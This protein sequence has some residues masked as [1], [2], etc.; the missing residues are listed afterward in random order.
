VLALLILGFPIILVVAWV[1]ELT[2]KGLVRDTDDGAESATD[3]EPDATPVPDSEATASDRSIAVLPFVNMSD[4]PSNEYFSDGL[5]EELLNVLAQIPELHV[6]AR[7]SSFSFKG[8]KVDIPTVARKLK[9]ANVLEGSVRKAGDRVRITAQLVQAADGYHLWSETFDRTLED[10]F[11]VQDEIAGSVVHALKVSLLGAV[12]RVTETDPEAYSSYLKG[13]YFLRS[14]EVEG[15]EKALQVFKRTLELD[16]GHAPAW[17]ALGET[18]YYMVSFGTMKREDGAA[19]AFEA[20]DR[21]LELDRNLPEAHIVRAVLSMAFRLDWPTA[22]AALD[23]ARQLAPG[24]ARVALLTGNLAKILGHFDE[25]AWRLKQAISLD[26]L[27]TTGH[28]WLSQ[29]LIAQQRLAEA[30]EVLGQALELNPKR[31]VAHMIIGMTYLFEGDAAAGHEEMQKEP[32][33][34]WRDFGLTMS[35]HA[36]SPDGQADSALQY[37]IREHAEEGPFQVGEAYAA[38]GD[39]DNAFQW[40]ERA[41]EVRDPGTTELLT[42]QSLLGLHDDPR[43]RPLLDRVRLEPLT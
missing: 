25:A 33:G 8:E 35:E 12:P 3:S 17:A 11:A 2:P 31:A 24:S 15:L 14:G 26:P 29:V 27:N 6:A 38:R 7:T 41:L 28:I 30:R 32:P 40:L 36:L 42:S 5:T 34:F 16:P 1:Y 10:I 13:V 18:Y 39:R 4:D 19:L 37:L 43:W 21:A 22:S 23:H 9:V 20:S